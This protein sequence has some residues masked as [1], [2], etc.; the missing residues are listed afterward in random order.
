[1][2]FKDLASAYDSVCIE[3]LLYRMIHEYGYDGN[4]IA[5]FRDYLTN[6]M[7]RVVYNG[8][9]TEWKLALNNLPQGGSPSCI[10]FVLMLN[11]INISNRLKS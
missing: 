10:L 4:I 8:Y 3:G 9:K 2:G 5:W 6:R 1:M 7:T 11:D